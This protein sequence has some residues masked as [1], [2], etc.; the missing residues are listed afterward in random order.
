MA[1]YAYHAKSG[2]DSASVSALGNAELLASKIDPVGK[3]VSSTEGNVDVWWAMVSASKFSDAE[4][5]RSYL[6]SEDTVWDKDL[7]CWWRGYQDPV[8]AMNAATWLSAFARHPLVNKPDRSKAAL[9]FV[10]RTLVT[11]SDDGSLCGFDGMGPVS[12]WNEG[13]AQYVAAG[14]QDAEIFLDMLLSQQ[15]EDGSMPGSPDTWVSNPLVW[16]CNWS[17]IAPTAWLYFATE[18]RVPFPLDLPPLPDITANGHKET[19][20][21]TPGDTLVIT[22]GLDPGTHAA[23]TPTGRSVSTRGPFHHTGFLMSTRAGPWGSRGV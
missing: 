6:L 4:K 20:M 17:G 7:Q 15:R 19:V 14:G 12:I 16:L 9:S 18:G 11:L 3:V 13:T 2:D 1:L 22:V 10:R 23:K 8:V 21:L 5:I